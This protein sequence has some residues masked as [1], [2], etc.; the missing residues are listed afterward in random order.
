MPW[1]N[2]VLPNFEFCHTIDIQ[3]PV[4]LQNN[5]FLPSL[6]PGTRRNLSWE[7]VR[8]RGG[9]IVSDSSR[10]VDVSI[11]STSASLLS[12]T[13]EWMSNVVNEVDV[14]PKDSAVPTKQMLRI[15]EDAENYQELVLNLVFYLAIPS[16]DPVA[17][18]V[19]PVPVQVAQRQELRIQISSSYNYNSRAEVLLITNPAIDVHQYQAIK[20]FLCDKL[21]MEMD[22]WNV[23][24][25]GGLQ[26]TAEE[27][28]TVGESVLSTYSGQTIVF[29]GNRFNFFKTKARSILQFCNHN[30]LAGTCAQGT[31]CLFLDSAGDPLYVKLL[32]DLLVPVPDEMIIAAKVPVGSKT[33]SKEQPRQINR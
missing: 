13:Q 9:R 17:E 4:E 1:L 32:Q 11:N 8:T 10:E 28:Q 16:H 24:L 2:H 21:G 12:S 7:S 33:F 5:E 25:Y 20:S 18:D 27:A 22:G 30:A 31:S 6:A 29:L 15:S 14:L 23:G 3:F 26:Y 19:R